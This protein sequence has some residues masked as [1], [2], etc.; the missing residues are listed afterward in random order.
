[1]QHLVCVIDDN[2]GSAS[3]D[4]MAAINAY[5]DR[6]EA[7]EHWVFAGGLAAPSTSLV[8]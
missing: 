2:T 6:L 3:P 7:D 1:M 8:P 4:E 5:N